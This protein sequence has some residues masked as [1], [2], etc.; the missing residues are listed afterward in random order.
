MLEPE[1][2]WRVRVQMM[3]VLPVAGRDSYVDGR[4]RMLIKLGSVVPVVDAADEKIDQ[5]ALLRFLGEIVWFP[6]AALSPY[7]R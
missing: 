6:A 2:I 4:G 1:F 5:G 7:I 3:H